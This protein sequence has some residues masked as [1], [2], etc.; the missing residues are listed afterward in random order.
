MKIG[1][2]GVG[3][4][5]ATLTSRLSR[6]GHEVF[7]ANSRGPQTI[8]THVL[9][10]GGQAVQAENI[11]EGVDALIISIPLS[12]IPDIAP[13]IARLPESAVMLDTSNY[14]PVRDGRID[15][16]E[17][18]QP[19]S[20]WVIDQLN[21]RPLVK[22][23]NAISASSF[24]KKAAPAGNA[25]RIALPVAADSDD[26]RSVGISLVGDTGFDGLD[27]GTLAESWRQQPGT[28]AYCTDFSSGELRDALAS[29]RPGRAPK[30]RDLAAAV[31]YELLEDP[32][33]DGGEL[34]VRINR[35]IYTS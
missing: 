11:V 27:A 29:A 20:Q 14:Y 8:P 17:D 2:L 9:A 18:G 25:E 35:L 4:I 12:R 13:L 34:L 21:G 31:A 1:I 3:S 26:H 30:R 28:P 22:A 7:V 5:G 6:V 33:G 19:E 32:S 16:I 10:D 15:A 24:A 23:W